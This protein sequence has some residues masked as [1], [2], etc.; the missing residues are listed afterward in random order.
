[1][2]GKDPDPILISL[3][4]GFQEST[5]KVLNVKKKANI[6][7]KRTSKSQ[8]LSVGSSAG[9]AEEEA[10]DD[11]GPA[12]SIPL[13]IV[14]DMQDEIRKLKAMIVKHEKRIRTLEAAGTGGKD[15][16]VEKSDADAPPP[17]PTS[18]PPPSITVG[19]NSHSPD[20]LAPD[21]V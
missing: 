8:H 2:E 21:E 7:D 5:K 4:D 15:A 11:S 16:G 18:E 20:S 12:P 10:D 6:L 13:K 9:E 3:K 17:L 14:E 19:S 1:M